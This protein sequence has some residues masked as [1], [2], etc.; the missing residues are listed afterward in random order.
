M[1]VDG[2][3]VFATGVDLHGICKE[4]DQVREQRQIWKAS[5]LAWDGVPGARVWGDNTMGGRLTRNTE[6]NFHNFI[7][8]K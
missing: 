1:L 8:N 4:F 5:S 6:A 3:V 7:I 2:V